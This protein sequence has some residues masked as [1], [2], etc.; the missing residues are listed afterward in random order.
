MYVSR[1]TGLG[2]FH[3]AL[4]H[5]P[6]SHLPSFYLPSFHLLRLSPQNGGEESLVTSAGKSCRLLPPCSGGTNPIAQR[7]Q[8]YTQHFV[9]SAKNRQLENELLSVDYTLKVGEKQFSDV[10]KRRKSR[11]SRSKFATVGLGDRLAH[12]TL[13]L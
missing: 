9:H 4:F 10:W 1:I 3:L 13:Q 11:E 7:N 12:H 2:S 6:S 8:V 5:L